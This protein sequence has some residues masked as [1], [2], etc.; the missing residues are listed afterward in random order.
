MPTL[1]GCL[2][3]VKFRNVW[4][5]IQERGTIKNIHS[6]YIQEIFMYLKQADNRKPDGIGTAGMAGGK[7]TVRRVIQ[8]WLHHQLV[9]MGTVKGI[10]KED[11][12]KTIQID[13]PGGK[14]GE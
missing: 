5:D 3:G 11:V 8:I 10:Q 13:Q 4:L 14:P 12:G 2:R 1:T 6:L 9:T 7:E